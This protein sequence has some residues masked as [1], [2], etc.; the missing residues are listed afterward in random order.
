[1]EPLGKSRL[2]TIAPLTQLFDLPATRRFPHLLPDGM[3]AWSMIQAITWC[4]EQDGC[5][6]RTIRRRIAKYKKAGEHALEFAAR[7]DKGL[8]RFFSQYGKAAVLAAAAG[9]D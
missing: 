4:A 2:E 7:R 9:N 8:S 1:M 5:H 3:R 6:V